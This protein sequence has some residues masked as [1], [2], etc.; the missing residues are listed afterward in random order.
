MPRSLNDRHH[1]TG[2]Q[3]ANQGFTQGYDNATQEY[4]TSA[5]QARP[6]RYSDLLLAMTMGPGH[7]ALSLATEADEDL[8]TL[9][10]KD[11]IGLTL[12]YTGSGR[13]AITWGVVH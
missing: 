3:S 5:V 1:Y 9:A 8:G 10:M 12:F 4:F 2:N 11:A 6:K 7:H 13:Y